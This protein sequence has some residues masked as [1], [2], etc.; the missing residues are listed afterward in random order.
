MKK[1]I[2]GF[3]FLVLL[4]SCNY[5]QSKSMPLD[6]VDSGLATEKVD[7]SVVMEKVM[8]KNCLNCHSNA[9]GNRGGLNL[10][11]YEDV[12]AVAAEIKDLVSSRTMPPR[13]MTALTDQQIQLLVEWIDA[14]APLKAVPDEPVPEPNPEP[15]P[16][17]APVPP[18][19]TVPT[20][21]PVPTT[22]PPVVP[23]PTPEPTPAPV[24]VPVPVGTTYEMVY[25]QVIQPSCLKCHSG[26][27]AG[28]VNLETYQNLIEFK[29]EVKTTISNGSMPRRSK[30]T[31]EQKK[32]ILEWI[33]AGAPEFG[34]IK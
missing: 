12:I 19:T 33:D 11:T 8:V 13:R 16:A 32:L 30:L 28:D 5:S 6:S 34:V 17:P 29:N 22:T 4:S 9:G 25:K 3:S 27:G 20:P 31:A 14:G 15:T 23:K 26:Q 10:E 2:V 24:P 1:F 21:D 18:P 7:F